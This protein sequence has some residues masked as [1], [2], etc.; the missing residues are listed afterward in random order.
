MKKKWKYVNHLVFYHWQNT[1]EKQRLKY[2]LLP[3]ACYFIFIIS[4]QRG[5]EHRHIPTNKTSELGGLTQPANRTVFSE[6]KTISPLYKK[7]NPAFKATGVITYDPRLVNNIS[8][9]FSGRI[10]KLYVRSN[11]ENIT[12]GQRIMDLYSPEIVTTQQN[13]IFLLNNSSNDE[14]LLNA[15]KQK[16]LLLGL[17]QEQ[18]KQIET[19]RKLINP[20][21]VFSPYNGHIHDIG[22]NNEITSASSITNGMSLGMNSQATTS[23]QIQ[24]ENLP[25][26]STSSLTIKEGMYIQSGQ[27]LFSVYNTSQVWAILNVFPQDAAFIKIGNKVEISAETNSSNI[28]YSTISYIDPVTG[29]NASAIKARVYLQNADN[30]NLTIGTLLTAKIFPSEINGLW[31]PCN[32]VV[33]LGQKQV[34]FL[35][36]ENY[37]MAKEILTGIVIDSLVLV[38]GLIGDDQVAANGQYMVD[39]ESFIKAAHDEKR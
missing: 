34:V 16:L 1:I 22:T 5:D 6:V 24:I 36:K 17:T 28:V 29:E 39:S 12:K 38:K 15:S 7:I 2:C 35:R 23:S 8:A 33:N 18:L 19:N 26:S 14:T 21:P 30:L 11:F 9:R 32:A 27:A 10:E 20:I 37:F 31:L 3:I 13:L 25:T 4:C